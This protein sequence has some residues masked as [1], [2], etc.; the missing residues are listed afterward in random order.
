MKESPIAPFL[1]NEKKPDF[2]QTDF[3]AG[4]IGESPSKGARSPVLW[5]AAF[6]GLGVSAM[7][8]PMDV[9]VK[10]LANVVEAMRSDR[11]FIGSAV[12]VPHKQKVVE[13]LAERKLV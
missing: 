8:H 5:N 13:F 4:I 9:T 2:G 11:R 3:Y 6:Q 1:G 12:A 7:M 10:D